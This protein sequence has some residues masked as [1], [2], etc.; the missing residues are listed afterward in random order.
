MT[1]FKGGRLVLIPAP[2]GLTSR[3]PNRW[4]CLSFSPFRSSDTQMV[5]P[6]NICLYSMQLVSICLWSCSGWAPFQ[7]PLWFNTSQLQSYCFRKSEIPCITK[8]GQNWEKAEDFQKEK[9][10]ES[11]MFI[12]P[13]YGYTM[14]QSLLLLMNGSLIVSPM[15]FS[16]LVG[17]LSQ[18]CNGNWSFF[19][20]FPESSSHGVHTL[21]SSNEPKLSSSNQALCYLALKCMRAM[22]LHSLSYCCNH[23]H[24]IM[25]LVFCIGVHL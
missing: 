3:S 11:F 15:E 7:T 19:C 14:T 24:C 2:L 12:H 16:T 13:C 9:Q 23:F 8:L 6:G 5:C 22:T 4:V 10:R 17:C 21:P 1:S 25:Q 20:P 18:Q